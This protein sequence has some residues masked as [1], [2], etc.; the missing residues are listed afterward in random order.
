[1]IY[2]DL[3]RSEQYLFACR[4]GG[5]SAKAARIGQMMSFTKGYNMERGMLKWKDHDLPAFRVAKTA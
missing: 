1:M 4:R 3:P 2:Q 5:R